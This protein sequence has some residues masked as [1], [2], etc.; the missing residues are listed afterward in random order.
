M[1]VMEWIRM[2]RRDFLKRAGAFLLF[3]GILPIN[4]VDVIIRPPGARRDFLAR[5]IRCGECLEACPYDSIRFLDITAGAMIHT[6][7][8]DPLKTPC[9]LCQQRG[10]DGKDRPISRYLRCGEVCPTGALKK[11]VNNKDV[12]ANVPE[13]IRM[14]VS[15]INRDICL[16]WQ[17][18]V[19]GECYYNCPLKDMA[20]KDRPPSESL[21]EN[22]GIRPYVDPKHCIGCGMCNYVCP[23]KRHI[24]ESVM[25]R[26]ARLSYFEE[27]YAS[28]VRNLTGRAGAVRLPAVRVIKRL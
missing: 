23:V 10:H 5:C 19:C 18:D 15:V 2:D 7:Y 13:E 11:I 12:L 14:G 24:A 1:A 8:I 25:A 21:R 3:I 27:R 9:Y 20:M 4:P 6:P 22:T 28:M 26:D 16:A 17:Y